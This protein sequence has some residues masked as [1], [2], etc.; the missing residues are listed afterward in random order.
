M[1]GRPGDNEHFAAG[2]VEVEA[3]SEAS[4]SESEDAAH[5]E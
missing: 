4:E 3:A 1:I 5:G 2:G